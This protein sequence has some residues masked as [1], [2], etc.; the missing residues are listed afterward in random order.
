MSRD[1]AVKAVAEALTLIPGTTVT[2]PKSVA[3]TVVDAV[4]PVIERAVRVQAAAEVRALRHPTG[5]H[6]KGLTPEEAAP[7]CATC[8]RFT[9]AARIVEGP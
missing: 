2:Y 8:D 9:A 5:Y 6:R 3:A 4:W 7:F 1:E